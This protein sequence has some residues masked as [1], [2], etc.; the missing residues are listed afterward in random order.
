MSEIKNESGNAN[1]NVQ[2]NASAQ[3]DAAVQT[4]AGMQTDTNARAEKLLDAIGMVDEELIAEAHAD[5]GMSAGVE[6]PAGDNEGPRIEAFAGGK[7]NVDAS[8]QPEGTTARP[9]A[10]RTGW[11]KRAIAAAACLILHNFF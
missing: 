11:S 9:Q 3:A 6:A 8:D 5:D 7:A 4:N 2:L 1:E 10:K